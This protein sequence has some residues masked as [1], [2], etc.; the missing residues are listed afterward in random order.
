[1][2]PLLFLI[3]FNDIVECVRDSEVLVYADELKLFRVITSP[4]DCIIL[5]NDINRVSKWCDINSFAINILKCKVVLYYKSLNPLI[6]HYTVNSTILE[7]LSEI[8]DFGVW[9]D[10]KLKFSTHIT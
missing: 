9:F 6:N 5:Q 10:S 8:K 2:S 1:M 3:Y 4:N 7:R